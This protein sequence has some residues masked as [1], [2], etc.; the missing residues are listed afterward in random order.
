MHALLARTA[1]TSSLLVL[2]CKS[3]SR[4]PVHLDMKEMAQPRELAAP[5]STNAR[6]TLTIASRTQTVLTWLV[7]LSA[8]VNLDSQETDIYNAKIL[9]NAKTGPMNVILTRH[10]QIPKV[11]DV[12]CA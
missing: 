3:G 1:A 6:G 7:R 11:G 9:M 5:T 4:V 8:S 10:A 2:T 12:M